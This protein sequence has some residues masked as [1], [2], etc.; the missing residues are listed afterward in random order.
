MSDGVKAL[1]IVLG[2]IGSAIGLYFL[3]LWLMDIFLWAI[4]GLYVIGSALGIV[5][6]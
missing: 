3:V 2:F 5:K 6:G 4:M 1:L